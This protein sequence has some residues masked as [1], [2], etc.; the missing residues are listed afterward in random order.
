MQGK[1]G[2]EKKI[3]EK[4]PIPADK[5]IILQKESEVCVGKSILSNK[6]DIGV[7]EEGR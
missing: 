4:V 3:S 7:V 1:E 5:T 2:R 6:M